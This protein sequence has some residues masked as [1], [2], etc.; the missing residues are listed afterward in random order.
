MGRSPGSRTSQGG[1]ATPVR[2]PPVAVVE[3][4]RWGGPGVHEPSGDTAS[5]FGSA[6]SL[7]R[8]AG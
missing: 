5:R 4:G 7:E 2:R 6:D 1:T 3:D 8:S